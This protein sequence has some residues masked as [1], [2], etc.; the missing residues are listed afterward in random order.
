MKTRSWVFLAVTAAALALIGY[1]DAVET[2]IGRW[3]RDLT[4]T[5][6]ADSAHGAPAPAISAVVDDGVQTA[7]TETIADASTVPADASAPATTVPA[8][9]LRA[10]RLSAA[11]ARTAMRERWR[12]QDC[13]A[14]Q[15]QSAPTA[16]KWREL[17]DWR[18][19]PQELAAAERQAMA[20]AAARLTAG[21]PAP[22]TDKA[23]QRRRGEEAQAMLAAAQAAGDLYARL[24]LSSASRDTAALSVQARAVLY[25]AVLSGDP[26]AIARL[27]R[28]ENL[29]RRG[30]PLDLD[31]QFVDFMLWPLV[32][33]D[34]GLDCGPGS[35]A[36]DR[37]CLELGNGCGYPSLDAL[38][39]D[40]SPSWLYNL[41]DQR[42][43]ELVERIRSGQIA[44]M[45]DPVVPQPPG[46]G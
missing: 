18:W 33:C 37:A 7:P 30:Q 13:Q 15:R 25:D 22:I 16:F 4:A 40:R 32:A 3:Q 44:G 17:H 24:E 14:A 39:R 28:V 20:E 42:R 27:W 11:E 46:G 2:A 45:F 23:E 29:A 1:N 31:G 26:E 34:L 8:K 41:T 10:S 36:L 6:R 21:C 19:L 35:R 12:D 9:P 38:V 43:R 5:D